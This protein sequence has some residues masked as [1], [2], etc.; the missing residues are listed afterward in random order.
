NDGVASLKSYYH[1]YILYYLIFRF[2]NTYRPKQSKYFVI[3]KFNNTALINI[4]III[5]G[6]GKKSITFCYVENNVEATIKAAFNEQYNNQTIN[7]GND[8]ETPI[9]EL[10]NTI[11]KL[12]NSSS[13]I[14]HLP[15]LEEGDMTRRKPDI[16]KM[17]QLLN[18]KPLITLEDGINR[19]LKD[20]SFIINQS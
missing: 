4:E 8:H 5:Y 20:T 19:I 6:Y 14:I 3:H 11:I 15:P 10:A 13:K 17:K 9:L 7:I 2:F 16:T 1:S 18:G 12:T